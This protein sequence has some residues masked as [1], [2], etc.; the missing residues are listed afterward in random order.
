MTT[1]TPRT[2]VAA[3]VDCQFSIPMAVAGDVVLPAG[4][5][6]RTSAVTAPKVFQL[7]A[8]LTIP[9]GSTIAVE[10]VENSDSE[11][12]TFESDG[13]QPGPRYRLSYWLNGSALD[14]KFE[15]APPGAEYKAYMS[16]TSKKD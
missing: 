16:W 1:P 5:T 11:E 8:A 14:G 15:V 13:T 2:A 12:D 7:L 10:S 4:A 6:V 3:T 9:H